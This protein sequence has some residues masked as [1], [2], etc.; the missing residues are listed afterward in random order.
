MASGPNIKMNVSGISQFKQNM[1]QAQ[2]SVKT[3]DEALKLNEKQFKATGDAEE[4]MD[5]KSEL[6][7]KKLEEQKK[8]VE[9]AEKALEKMNDEGVSKT[10][11]S[12]QQMQQA[13]YRARGDLVDT[14]RELGNI[15]TAAEEADAGVAGMQSSLE[16]IG[17]Q[18]SFKTVTEGIDTITGGLEKAARKAWEIGSQLVRNTLG[19]GSWADELNTEAAKLEISPEQ[20]YRM[21][22]TADIIDTSAEAIAGAQNRMKKV[23]DGGGSGIADVL[24]ELGLST[25][26][27]T[28]PAE[29][30]W[31]IGEALMAMGDAYDKEGTA[32][33]IFGKS[34][35]NSVRRWR[36][37]SAFSGKRFSMLCIASERGEVYAQPERHS[38]HH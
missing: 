24:Q 25:A 13:L 34:W 18:I 37:P 32:Q 4:Y 27:E 5:K 11:A 30:F 16:G 15:G 31:K 9:Q 10:S 22:Q 38:L 17:K 28:D 33:K 26:I 21:R 29:E 12:F 7:T 20:L 8:I 19:G 3:L 2:T 1:K 14:E 23:L 36:F 35:Q 6:L